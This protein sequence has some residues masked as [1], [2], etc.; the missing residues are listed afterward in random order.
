MTFKEIM[1]LGI[2]SGFIV[3]EKIG[4]N[5]LTLKRKDG[6]RVEL[7]FPDDTLIST[8][9]EGV[10]INWEYR[11]IDE[12]NDKVFYKDW[13]DIY[14]GTAKDK[15]R[16][17][18]DQVL[19]FM[20]KIASLELQVEEKSVFTLFGLKLLKYKVLQFR[21]NGGWKDFC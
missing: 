9:K 2:K 6:I 16:D 21:T 4:Y 10:N 7:I 15:I 3:D 13:L 20:N 5:F 8:L 12:K 1:D 17:V 11:L 14:G 18:K 19:E